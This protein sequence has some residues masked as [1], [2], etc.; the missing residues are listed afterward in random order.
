M[1]IFCP[2]IATP[3]LNRFHIPSLHW[4][5][6]AQRAKSAVT[7]VRTTFAL[8]RDGTLALHNTKCEP[9]TGNLS[10]KPRFAP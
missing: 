10:I 8:A 2:A 5:I 9:E 3:F 4:H 7:S 1:R 6:R